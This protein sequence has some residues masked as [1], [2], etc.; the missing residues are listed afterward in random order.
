M[1][2]IISLNGLWDFVADLDPKY[3]NDTGIHGSV[4]YSQPEVNRRHWQ[5]VPV[6]GVWQKYAERYDIYEGICW[7]AREFDVPQLPEGAEAQLRFGAVNYLAQVYL[8]GQWVGCHEGGYTEF[9]LDVRR[10]LKPGC[11]QIAVMVDNRATTVKWPPCLGYFNYGGIHRSVCLE[12][13]DCPWLDNVR[14]TAVPDAECGR[15]SVQAVVRKPQPWL[16]V[17]V[18]SEGL[19][20]EDPVSEDGTVNCEVPFFGAEAWTP[21]SPVLYPLRV[22]LVQD[23]DILVDEWN[24]FCGFRSLSIR[25]SQVQVNGQPLPLRG[26]CYVYDSPVTGLV[27]TPEQIE[28]DLC[29]MKEAGCNAVRCHYPMDP[30]FYAACDRLGLLAWIEPPVYC[31]HPGDKETGTRFADPEW[32]SLARQM[33][34]E[35]IA[36]ARNH[37]SVAIYSIGNECNTHNPEAGAFFRSLAAA[38]R[39]ADS[40][41]L[42][43]YAALYG[44]IGPIADIVDVLG[45][46]AYYG[47][48]DQIQ[49]D[50]SDKGQGESTAGRE[51]GDGNIHQRPI[52]LTPM[53]S[54]LD[55]ALAGNPHLALLLT[56]FGA[57]SVPGAFS[58]SRNLWSEEYHA[59][60]LTEIFAL[61]KEYPQIAGTFPF[62]F[63]DYRDPSKPVNGCWNE[64][65]LKGIVDYNRRR[66]LAFGAV[67]Q[68]Y[69]F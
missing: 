39:E 22:G 41:R 26:V 13:M 35:M 9:V 65:N 20:W 1:K 31:Y 15:L 34:C 8:N 14:I 37:P 38:I 32:M 59:D 10:H 45:I 12:I 53:R 51:A 58:K 17:R 47:W 5:R 54:M 49:L 25:D 21:G 16:K 30:L 66:K 52:D 43:S 62:C 44:N 4:L 67:Q 27:M 24:G 56:E 40:T 7:Y 3:H 6:P 55:T 68:A 36:V 57:D 33:A 64:L 19:S 69:R 60:L 50:G 42:V 2:Q 61:A 23:Q 63:T 28:S 48:Y 29:L 11:N 18:E 46:N